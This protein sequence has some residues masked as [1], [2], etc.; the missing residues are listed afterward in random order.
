MNRLQER[1][2]S[3]GLSQP[4]V[5]QALAQ[6]GIKTD[7]AMISR[8]EN[9]VCLPLPE[10][11]DALDFLYDTPEIA[12]DYIAMRR[13]NVSGTRLYNIWQGMKQRCSDKNCR[14]YERYGGRGIAVCEEW[15]HDYQAFKH[16]AMTHGYQDD[17]TIER[18]DVNGN[19]SPEN[20]RW[21]TLKEQA[22]NTRRNRRI[23]YRGV[24][25]TLTEWSEIFGVAPST[26][27]K[28]LEAGWNIE[29]A[30]QTSS[31]T[32]LQASRTELFGED[33]LGAIPESEAV[34]GA[35]ASTMTVTLAGVIP[36]GRRNAIS[37]EALAK[38]LGISDRQMRKAVEDARNEGLIILCECNGRGYYQSNDLNEIH[39]QYIQDTNRA[40]AILKRRKPMRQL[41]RQAGRCV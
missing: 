33:E 41:L 40:M 13:P 26:I 35:S 25:H 17:L 29:K 5:V 22:N 19:Y 23:T 12:E 37:R 27:R 28:R 1:R 34:G 21:A 4:E 10:T 15:Q 9:N 18:N 38:K 36:F 32:I 16:W 31:Q 30:L 20:C 11:Y 2:L 39:C 8:Y 6:M 14:S 24:T 3:L 7:V